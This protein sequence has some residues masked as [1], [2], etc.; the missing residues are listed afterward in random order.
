ML[1]KFKSL[2][3]KEF[4]VD[5]DPNK[6]VKDL[7]DA[8]AKEK[9]EQFPSE[10]QRLIYAGKILADDGFI[11]DYGIDAEKGF[12]VV[13]CCK[14]KPKS[15]DK[16]PTSCESPSVTAPST[17]NVQASTAATTA[18]TLAAS[19]STTTQVASTQSSTTTSTT[20]AST[21]DA[22]NSVT[23]AE[24]QLVTGSQYE[25]MVTELSS[26]GYDRQ[27]VVTA[28]RRSFNNPDRAAE[29]LLSGDSLEEEAMESG[30]VSSESTAPI[31]PS[32]IIGS[33]GLGFLRALPQFN[34]MREMVQ[35]NPSSLPRLLQELG[36]SN[37]EL[38]Q[39]ISQ[40]QE[41]F[42]ALLNEPV[43]TDGSQ[44]VSGGGLGGGA[45]GSAQ[46]AV[47]FGQSGEGSD[48]NQYIQVTPQEKEAIERLKA[49]G[50]SE[51]LVIQAYFACDKNENLAAN[52]LL[53]Q[54]FD[55]D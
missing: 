11:K 22:A 34:S 41:E 28:L 8:V 37:P 9:P 23:S 49:L 47:P 43:G 14:P 21:S 52:F 31:T 5:I 24:S 42:I 30:D 50:F 36:Q 48:G 7:K 26:L 38:L 44:D 10:S 29:Y 53:S 15:A 46:P 6:T 51:N 20:T 19:S 27:Q 25:D 40:R 33:S 45:L 39:R 35:T 4:S 1:I 12:V 54:G 55:D 16:T 2:T 32:S 18:S 3:Q 17:T 13:M